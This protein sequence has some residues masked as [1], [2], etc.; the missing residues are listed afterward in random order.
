MGSKMSKKL[1]V[2]LKGFPTFVTLKWSLTSV[3]SLM[4]PKGC[5]ANKALSTFLALIGF[6]IH[7]N[8]LMLIELGLKTESRPTLLTFK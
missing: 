2:I 5:T 1:V 3:D 7:M 8:S 6:H 4:N